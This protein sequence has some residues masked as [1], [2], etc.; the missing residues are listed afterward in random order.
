MEPQ[1]SVTKAGSPMTATD[2]RELDRRAVLAG[3]EV[4]SRASAPDPRRATPCS[5]WP[6]GDLLIHVTAQ[7]HAFADPVPAYAGAADHVLAAFAAEGVP[8][9]RFALSGISTRLTVPGAQALG[10]SPNWPG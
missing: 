10:R 1:H 5:H 7:H 8:A 4:V 2:I 6:L 9:R 3:T